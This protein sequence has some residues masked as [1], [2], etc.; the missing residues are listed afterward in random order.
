MS[1][2]F[3]TNTNNLNTSP[4]TLTYVG[5]E[6]NF[7]TK[8][9]LIE[10]NEAAYNEVEVKQLSDCLPDE[11]S[12]RVSWLNVD[13]IHEATVIESIGQQYQLH[14]LLLEDV[15]NTQQKPKMEYFGDDELFLTFKALT[16]NPYNREI[17][18]E[19]ISIAVGEG[20]LISFQE[21]REKDLF[22]P[23][24]ER[25]RASAG[26]TRRNG[27]DYLMF[28][29]L[30]VVVDGYFV[31]LEKVGERLEDLEERVTK[32]V[33]SRNLTD[34][35]DL[36]RELT[37]MRKVVYP[38]REVLGS[39][40]RNEEGLAFVRTTTLPYLRD[41][42]DHVTQAIETLDSYR[43][44]ITSLMDLHMSSMSNRL[45]DVM[46]ILTIISVVFLPLNLVVGFYGMNFEHMPELRWR[47][48]EFYV[49]GIM[50]CLV[51]T[52]LWYF[53]RKK[54]L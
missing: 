34:I 25:I 30:D 38:L 7:A 33:Q 5:K 27:S 3:K 24:L 1:K 12:E 13:G 48:G 43:E 41:T 2:R 16:F 23:V 46:R 44:L 39:L 10:Y 29:L 31:V 14:P 35:Y 47:Y 22:A 15:M 42:Y 32:D 21:E 49:M 11:G 6:V 19:H 28:T 53:R 9:H 40:V 37:L 8:I 4:G 17:D 20:W 45:N 54:W 50:L 51:L 26:K 18:Q 52:M 36:K